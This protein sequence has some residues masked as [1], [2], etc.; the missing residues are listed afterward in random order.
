MYEA[1]VWLR[2][3]REQVG[4]AMPPTEWRYFALEQANQKYGSG[5]RAWDQPGAQTSPGLIAFAGAEAAR[6]QGPEAFDAFHMALLVLRHE[7]TAELER[8]TL[9]RAAREASLDLERFERDLDAPDILE[10]LAR[11][12]EG[13]MV[14]GVFGTPTIYFGEGRGAYLKMRPATKGADAARV[15]E[16]FRQVVSGELNIQE[17]KRPG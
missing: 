14:R 6:R 3:V 10:P 7:Q 8:A 11:D 4:D 16:G 5:W 12:H 17:I 15:F 9:V 13:A 1:A 2:N